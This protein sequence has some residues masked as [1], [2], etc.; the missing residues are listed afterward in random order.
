MKSFRKVLGKLQ[1]STKK[2][3]GTKNG[4]NRIVPRKYRESKG[5]I[6]IPQHHWY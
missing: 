5:T 4:G 6:K 3:L 1:K 2:V